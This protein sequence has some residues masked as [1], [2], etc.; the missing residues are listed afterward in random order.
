[1]YNTDSFNPACF[2][3]NGEL[4]LRS[5][6][7]ITYET[8]CEDN[9]F[10]DETGK[11]IASIF[12]YAYFRTDVKNRQAR[13]V[14]F[15]FNGGPGASSMAV[16]AGCF[17]AKRIKYPE[18]TEDYPTLPPYEVIDN[19]DCLL[20]VADLVMVDPIDTGFGLLLDQ[21]SGK[22]FYGIDEDAEALL[23][24]ISHWLS[25]HGRWGSP[26]YLVGESYGCTRAAV[27]AGIGVN[28]GLEHSY[29]MVFDGVCFIGNTVTVETYFNRHPPVDTSVLAFTTMASINWYHKHPT[30]QSLEE[31]AN[32]AQDFAST[33]YLVAL[34]KGES[35]VGEEREAIKKKIMYYTGVSSECL[36]HNDLRLER[37]TF[38]KDLLKDEGKVVS[39]LDGRFTRPRFQPEIHEN[40]PGYDADG[41][42]MRYYAFLHAALCGEIFD[43]LGIKNFD[44]S[45]VPFRK[46]GTWMVPNPLWDFEHEKLKS[47]ERLS[48]AMH[49][50]QKMRT[51]FANGWFD[52]VT[53]T[54]IVYHTV[55]HSHL[56]KDRTFFKGYP[57]GHLAYLGEHNV[58]AFSEDL[59]KFVMGQ[60]PSQD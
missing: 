39:I 34:Y 32:E 51:F 54:G 24:F 43:S 38:C 27:A 7:H 12:S 37:E 21:E 57:S 11:P 31:F 10:Y 41:T 2:R 46:L 35:L 42:N 15:C 55:N 29:D 58:R 1:M 6:E 30:G 40:T 45:F 60:D 52:L 9:L 3:S 48:I 22:R 53:Q 20:D 28:D 5:G 13:P 56:P 25:K 4:T 17:G 26:K 44:R 50:N 49:S 18:H 59:R 14:L 36:D 16:H 23:M 33:D 8:V 19:P 47:S